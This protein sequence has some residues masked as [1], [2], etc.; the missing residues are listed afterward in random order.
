MPRYA[1]IGDGN[2]TAATSL[3]D[4]PAQIL[5]CIHFPNF[6]E[7][8]TGDDRRNLRKWCFTINNYTEEDEQ[9]LLDKL[10]PDKVVYAIVGREKGES[11]TPHLQ[12]YVYFKRRLNMSTPKARLGKTAHLEPARGTPEQNE[13]YC[14]KD[15]DILLKIGEPSLDSSK[16][17]SKPERLLGTRDR[18]QDGQNRYDHRRGG[19]PRGDQPRRVQRRDVPIL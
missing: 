15:G 5:K 18:S 13:Q 9:N 14:S 6:G 16:K 10:T 4:F 8:T 12:G 19:R 1:S 11:G 17:P 7:L 3:P 2:T